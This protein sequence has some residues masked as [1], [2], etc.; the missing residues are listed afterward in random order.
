MRHLV[1]FFKDG[2]VLQTEVSRQIDHFDAGGQQWFATIN[3]RSNK[4]EQSPHRLLI[5]DA[6]ARSQQSGERELQTLRCWAARLVV[7]HG[8]ASKQPNGM[9]VTGT[10]AGELV[11]LV[12]SLA[13]LVAGRPRT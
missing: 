5:V 8:R 3:V 1:P 2:R 4:G 7:R 10:E 11:D 13:T 9:T 6:E 12:E